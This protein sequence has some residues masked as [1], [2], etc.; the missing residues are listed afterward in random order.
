MCI[1]M[2]L[3]G[4][5]HVRALDADMLVSGWRLFETMTRAALSAECR[6]LFAV[7]HRSAVKFQVRVFLDGLSRR[8]WMHPGGGRRRSLRLLSFGSVALSGVR[9]ARFTFQC[10]NWVLK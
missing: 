3:P 4:I 9:G 8:Y 10:W 5:L 2:K 7:M 6:D 1:W